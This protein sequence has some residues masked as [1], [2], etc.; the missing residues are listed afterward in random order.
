MD[1]IQTKTIINIIMIEANFIEYPVSE[2]KNVLESRNYSPS[3]ALNDFQSNHNE[4]L[5]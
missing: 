3:C 4:F 1:R 5:P 2:C